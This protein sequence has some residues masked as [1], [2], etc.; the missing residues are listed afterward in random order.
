MT[1]HIPVMLTEVLDALKPWD[2]ETTVIDATL[3]LGGHSREILVNCKKCKVIGFDQDPDARAIA[4]KNLSE[5]NGRFEIAADNFRHIEKI[6]ER[7]NWKGAS[8]VLF[9]LGVSNLQLTDAERGFSFQEDGPLDMRMDC[10]EAGC[11]EITAERILAEWTIKDLTEIFRTYGEDRFAYQIAKGI[12]RNRERGG[13]LHTTGEL[14]ELIRRIL[15]A[16]V[17]RKMGGH[18]ARKI[19]QALRIAVNDEMK[20][21]DEALN[22]AEKVLGPGGK[23]IAIS[24]HSLEDRMVKKRF[25][26]WR[27]EGI[28]EPDP[29]KAIVPSE[30]E[31]EKNHKS[32]SAKLRVFIKFAEKKGE[33]LN[34]L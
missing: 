9:D 19:F 13:E 2:S 3:G 22:G 33:A 32:R 14:V 24:Y 18:P 20:A 5:F 16:P 7:E 26:K 6:Q 21:L 4:A 1:E 15:P 28:G 31:I 34:A 25:R 23:I 10:G 17:Q 8:A 11:G 29:R 27:D 30:S 12:V